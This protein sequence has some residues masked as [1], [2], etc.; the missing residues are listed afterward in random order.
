MLNKSKNIDEYRLDFA[1]E[2]RIF[3]TYKYIEDCKAFAPF[4]N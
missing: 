2:I 4:F 1:E 3:W